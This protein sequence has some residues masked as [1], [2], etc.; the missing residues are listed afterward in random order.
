MAK[1]L[2]VDDDVH[3]N[4]MLSEALGTQGYEVVKA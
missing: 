4:D 2:I 1:I 3:I